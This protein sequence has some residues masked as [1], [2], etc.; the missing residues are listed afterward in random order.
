[1]FFKMWPGHPY[2]SPQGLVM[3]APWAENLHKKSQGDFWVKLPHAIQD[4]QLNLSQTLHGAYLYVLK[5]Y[6]LSEI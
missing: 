2:Q 6:Y 5:N 1:M 3:R 4:I